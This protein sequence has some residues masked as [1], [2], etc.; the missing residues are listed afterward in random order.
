MESFKD[1]LKFIKHLRT[2]YSDINLNNLQESKN[3]QETVLS[4]IKEFA[5]YDYDHD[6]KFFVTD[7]DGILF[8]TETVEL[9]KINRLPDLYSAIQYLNDAYQK[10]KENKSQANTLQLPDKLFSKPKETL[11]ISRVNIMSFLL[12]TYKLNSE[13]ELWECKEEKQREIIYDIY[14]NFTGFMPL[15]EDAKG[16]FFT[17][18]QEQD[19]RLRYSQYPNFQ[20]K[21]LF[22]H[23]RDIRSV[24]RNTEQLIRETTVDR[25]TQIKKLTKDQAKK[26]GYEQDE[27]QEL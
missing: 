11:D 13:K 8:A 16:I 27:T 1:F 5:N 15:K 2:H 17:F 21:D 7:I 14:R 18:P 23:I 24:K 10:R 20:H 19:M 22:S 12:E 25:I 6:N 3:G 26:R 4:I 9:E